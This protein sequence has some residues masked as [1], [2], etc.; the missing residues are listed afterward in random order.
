[1][2]PRQTLTNIRRKGSNIDIDR[3]NR[4]LA[5]SSENMAR[6]MFILRSDLYQIGY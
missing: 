3:Y 6:P 1:M 4:S 5:L 2:L